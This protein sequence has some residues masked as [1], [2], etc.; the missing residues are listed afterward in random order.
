MV[1][2]ENQKLRGGMD[3]K[4]RLWAAVKPIIAEWTGG[5]ELIETSLYGIRVYRPEA[6][7]GTCKCSR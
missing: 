2:F 3:L 4:S 1:S 6:I 5:K 7:L